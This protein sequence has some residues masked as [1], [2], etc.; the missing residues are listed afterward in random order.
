MHA[1]RQRASEQQPQGQE[2]ASPVYAI[3]FVVVLGSSAARARQPFVHARAR[4]T[5]NSSGLLHASCATAGWG[6]SAASRQASAS[7]RKRLGGAITAGE[8]WVGGGA[9]RRRRRAPQIGGETA[10]WPLFYVL[11]AFRAR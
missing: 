2:A 11:G 10:P 8:R 1:E 9:E 7:S 4:A 3:G 6:A 5:T